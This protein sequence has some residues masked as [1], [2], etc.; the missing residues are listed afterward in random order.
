MYSKMTFDLISAAA[1]LPLCYILTLKYAT[2]VCNSLMG[3]MLCASRLS[4]ID[5]IQREDTLVDELV[6]L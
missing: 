1:A 6:T 3:A 4:D 5:F 2:F